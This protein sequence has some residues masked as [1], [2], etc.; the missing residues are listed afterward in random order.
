MA[1]IKS[2]NS[3][4]QL[5]IDAVS[6]AARVTTYTS[7]GVEVTQPVSI[8]DF[9]SAALLAGATYTSQ[10]FDTSLNGYGESVAIMSVTNGTHFTDE[11]NDGTN[12]VAFDSSEV[13][14]GVEFND[15][16]TISSR[17]FRIRFVNGAVENPGGVS[18]F[19]HS[20]SQRASLPN[21]AQPI[22]RISDNNL[23][24]GAM[25]A[26]GTY[27]GLS[28][29]V[30]E[31]TTISIS[32]FSPYGVSLNGTL[33][34]QVSRNGN[35]W[36]NIPRD[37]RGSDTSQPITFLI[38]EKFFRI[39]WENG[40]DKTGVA[41]PTTNTSSFQIQVM[42]ANGR[43]MDLGH[44]MGDTIS[45]NTG[46][47]MTKSVLTG[48]LFSGKYK[49]IGVDAEGR[50]R[51]A[52]PMSAF[53]EVQVIQ[54]NPVVQLDFVYGINTQLATSIITGSG[55]ATV[56]A[57]LLSCKTTAAAN[58]SAIL[59]SRRYLK[60][61]AGQGGIAT[62]DALFTSGA[63]NSNQYAGLGTASL[64]NGFLFGFLGVTFGIFKIDNSVVVHT[65]QTAW[66]VDLMDG[67]NSVNNP[68]GMLLVKN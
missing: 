33:W 63:A 9:S 64:S 23:F 61:R 66:N 55:T 1:T 26:N 27:Q 43:V 10:T 38:A 29:V 31:F 11:S 7:A 46:G 5:R 13:V 52:N 34:I 12:W 36:S 48:R 25:T 68:S 67:S 57:G 53:D 19:F 59:H 35:D 16:K 21:Q 15:M 60:H 45:D 41:I 42:F 56:T 6:K 28:E 50:L 24:S 65:A 22:T 18:N 8:F 51:I 4:D 14:G 40:V 39:F 3:T 20:V 37:I 17:Y 49:N 44:Q 62:F 32:V 58:S 54:P 47:G 30:E 2:D